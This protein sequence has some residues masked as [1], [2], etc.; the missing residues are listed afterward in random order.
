[1]HETGSA[2]AT[3]LTDLSVAGRKLRTLF[4]ALVRQHGLTLSRARLLLHLDRHGGVT[5]SELASVL[6][7]EHPTVV[8]LLDGLESQGL[9]RRCAVAGDRRAKQVMLTEEAQPSILEM[10]RITAGMRER[11]LS[12]I[13]DADLAVA[14]RVL[15][16]VLTAMEAYAA[17]EAEEAAR[18]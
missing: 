15:S 8:R 14:S 13:G 7:L 5:Q 18:P 12:E 1:M 4:D 9:I 2:R 3:F 16:Q 6:E 17:A 11:L 10:E